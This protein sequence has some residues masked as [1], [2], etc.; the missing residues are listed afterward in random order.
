LRTGY[1]GKSGE[2]EALLSEVA[3]FFEGKGFLFSTE[4]KDSRI[5]VSIRTGGSAESKILDV[6]LEGDTNGSLVVTFE[7]PKESPLVRNSALPSLLGGGFLTL[8][9]LKASE[10]IERLEREF[11]NMVDSFMASS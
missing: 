3:R 7:Q 10:I 9:R 5:V 1:P 8:K 11:W 4:R 6:S 2:L